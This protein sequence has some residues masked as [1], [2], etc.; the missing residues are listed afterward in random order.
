MDESDI[1]RPVR[2]VFDSG[3]LSEDLVL[4]ALE[5][6]H[7]KTPL[8]SAANVPC[9]DLSAVISSACLLYRFRSDFSGLSFD[10][11]SKVSPLMK[12]RPADVGLYSFTPITHPQNRDFILRTEFY[13]GLF[14]V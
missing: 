14:P 11:S 4:V 6:D 3:D 2:I 8:M 5:I 12:R 13:D 7:T 9:G 10:I 1:R